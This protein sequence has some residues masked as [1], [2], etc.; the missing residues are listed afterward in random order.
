MT[1]I[2]FNNE[3]NNDAKT[4][5]EILNNIYIA[6]EMMRTATSSEEYLKAEKL[7][8]TWNKKLINY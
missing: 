6:S 8:M 5:E 4:R 7:E 3:I 2:T 1:T